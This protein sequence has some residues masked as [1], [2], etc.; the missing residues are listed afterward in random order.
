MAFKKRWIGR[1][2][3]GIFIDIFL[4]TVQNRIQLKVKSI[5]DKSLR[6]HT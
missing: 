4:R 6:K 1:A 3:K 5:M 2:P